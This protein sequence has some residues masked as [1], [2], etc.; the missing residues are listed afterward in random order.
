LTSPISLHQPTHKG[1]HSDVVRKSFELKANAV[2]SEKQL[3]LS[4]NPEGHS[5]TIAVLSLALIE[6]ATHLVAAYDDHRSQLDKP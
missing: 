6:R 4:K 5:E 2:L 3:V 1:N